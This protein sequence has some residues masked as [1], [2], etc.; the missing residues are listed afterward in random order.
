M[1]TW[2]GE[3]STSKSLL[4][5]EALFDS[6]T[7]PP[8]QNETGAQIIFEYRLSGL[9]SFQKD[10]YTEAISQ[11]KLARKSYSMQLGYMAFQG[12][13]LQFF[14]TLSLTPLHQTRP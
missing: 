11:K 1:S 2:R 10:L 9:N 12:R 6:G 13:E 3:I 7:P 5:S 14:F 8:A 4:N